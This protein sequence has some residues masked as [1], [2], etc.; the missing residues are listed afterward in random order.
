MAAESMPVPFLWQSPLSGK[1]S[2]CRG[3]CTLRAAA[4]CR[5]HFQFCTAWGQVM[6]NLTT[7]MGCLC[8]TFPFLLGIADRIKLQNQ[9]LL[10]R[11]KGNNQ[12][13]LYNTTSTCPSSS[14]ALYGTAAIMG[15]EGDSE[16]LQ[17]SG[18]KRDTKAFTEAAGK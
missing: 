17:S 12:C 18:S 2:C 1:R 5:Q 3:S 11:M 7:H 15:T 13:I 9:D 10:I 14:T 16:E 4:A 8:W 6:G